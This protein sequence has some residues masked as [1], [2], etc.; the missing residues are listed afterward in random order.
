M[1]LLRFGLLVCAM[2]TAVGVV[3][4]QAPGAARPEAPSA[5]PLPEAGNVLRIEACCGKV[6]GELRVELGPKGPAGVALTVRCQDMPTLNHHYQLSKGEGDLPDAALALQLTGSHG[7]QPGRIERSYFIRPDVHFYVG[8]DLERAVERW[9]EMP[10]ASA[11]WFQLDFGRRGER[12]EVS[13]DGRYFSSFPVPADAEVRWS[14]KD[15][16]E[17]GEVTTP[18]STQTPRFLPVD[19]S[20]TPSR[21]DQ[22]I[23][24]MPMGSGLQ[25]VGGVPMDVVAAGAAV[26][27]GL[28]RWLRQ[29]TGASTFYD[30]YYRRSAWDGVPETIMF[31]VPRRFYNYAHVLCG[32][33]EKGEG[34]PSMS[35]RVARY[36]I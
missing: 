23:A 18:V 35:V 16:A 8:E 17:V 33:E 1:S 31:S 27:V 20:R 29:E 28:S 25:D 14:V 10:A 2:A 24:A 30:P 11:H 34:S 5:R 4:G 15:G 9:S 13:L 21:G 12:I 19:I 7:W 3:R 6:G 22:P 26:D 36:P 32:V